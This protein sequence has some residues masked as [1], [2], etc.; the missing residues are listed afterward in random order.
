MLGRRPAGLYLLRRRRAAAR[1]SRGEALSPVPLR[2]AEAQRPARTRP[3]GPGPLPPARR[4]W[5]VPA[6]GRP[7][8]EHRAGPSGVV[9]EPRRPESE[10]PACAGPPPPPPAPRAPLPAAAGPGAPPEGPAEV[11]P[12]RR[13][14]AGARTWPHAPGRAAREPRG[15]RDARGVRPEPTRSWRRDRPAP[16]RAEGRDLG[17]AAHGGATRVADGAARRRRCVSARPLLAL[18]R[19][20][21]ALGTWARPAPSPPLPPPRLLAPVGRGAGAVDPTSDLRQL[22]PRVRTSALWTKI[23]SR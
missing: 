21:S 23:E 8:R 18:R 3:Q 13:R 19:A 11:R 20:P 10:T 7:R 2:L 4:E 16:T 14:G 12:A 1:G 15:A 9:G 5:E 6:E 22:D 17:D